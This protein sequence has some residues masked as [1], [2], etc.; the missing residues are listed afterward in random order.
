MTCTR[1]GFVASQRVGGAVQRN[2]AKRRLRAEVRAQS[3]RLTQGWD[4]VFIARRPLLDCSMPELNAALT[5]L[6][7]RASLL[8]SGQ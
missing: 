3:T 2:R 6:L 1:V 5:D 4:L 8:R 7:S